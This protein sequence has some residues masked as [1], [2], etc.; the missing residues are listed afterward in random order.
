MVADVASK[1]V[2]ITSGNGGRGE[3]PLTA[4][5][6]QKARPA[7]PEEPGLEPPDSIDPEPV[8][9]RLQEQLFE[10]LVES[11]DYVDG[12]TQ[13]PARSAEALQ[14]ATPEA[15]RT[16]FLDAWEALSHSLGLGIEP[17]KALLGVRDLVMYDI[18]DGTRSTL[19]VPVTHD[20][21]ADA[22]LYCLAVVHTLASLG[23]RTNVILT[24]TAYNR[25]RGPDETRRFLEI[26][27]KG[28]DPFREYARRHVI[29]I[30]LVGIHPGYELETALRRAFP[31]PE[32]PKFDAHFLM[33]YEEEWFL[34]PEGRDLL[35]LLPTIDVAVRHTKL[36]IG[37]GWIPIKMRKAAF[38]Y[39]QNGTVLS[40]WNF[41][42][43]AAM[44]A[45]S[46]LAKLLHQG[47]GLSKK[48]AT[49]EEIKARYRERELKLRQKIVRLT[50][51]PRK[52]FVLG[53][54]VG[55]IQVYA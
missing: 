38:V 14:L 25:E 50:P 26:M 42:E 51:K 9:H 36:G 8:D 17:E 34:T 49:I 19:S 10:S 24:H 11:A 2:I 37:G 7:P 15:I 54:P 6:S 52:L 45:V 23:A 46:Y 35:D 1:Y 53:S 20:V 44:V 32:R 40:N 18:P 31:F 21:D 39:S 48:Y 4:V 43:Y 30:H 55:L 22:G 5:S 41:D 33:D 12:R 13:L 29:A 3:S 47:E 16:A 28:I 27:A